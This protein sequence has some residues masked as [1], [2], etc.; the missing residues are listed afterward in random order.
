MQSSS[1]EQHTQG[2][3]Q[4]ACYLQQKREISWIEE[5]E[6]VLYSLPCPTCRGKPLKGGGKVLLTEFI[7]AA[8]WKMVWGWRLRTGI[9][10]R[11]LQLPRPEK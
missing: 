8:V 6:P 1:R 2:L 9:S 11:L 3:S 10:I 5:Q 7:L 4:S